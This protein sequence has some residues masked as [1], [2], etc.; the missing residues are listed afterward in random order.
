M[1]TRLTRSVLAF[2]LAFWS[3]A[4]AAQSTTGSISGVITDSSGG[5]LPGADIVVVHSDTGLQR[6][7]V[8][9]ATGY[10]RVLN[11]SP[12][13][14]SVTAQLSGFSRNSLDRVTVSVSRDVRV[15][16]ELRVGALDDRVVVRAEARSVEIGATTVG[17]VV[18][19]R[20]ISEL[21]LNGRSFMQ[22]ASLQPGVIVSRG[23]GKGFTGGFGQ[24]QPS[25]P[26]T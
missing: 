16:M 11:L 10:F 14:Y 4:A 12:G 17:G 18:S 23:S 26:A 19:T 24:M 21:P 2:V 8:T 22:L 7:Q 6:Q 15:D 3:G 20:Q 13:H 5:V 9:D 1:S 25:T